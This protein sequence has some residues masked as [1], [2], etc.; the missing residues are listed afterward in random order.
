MI[1]L[2]NSLIKLS[3]H[4][5]SHD[6]DIEREVL[7]P[8][9]MMENPF[10]ANSPFGNFQAGDQQLPNIDIFQLLNSMQQSQGGGGGF[11]FDDNPNQQIP[12]LAGLFASPL[13]NQQSS[14]QQQSQ[15]TIPD[16][17]LVKFLKTKL[18]IVFISMLIY[19]L[20]ATNQQ[21]YSNN[22]VFLY[23]LVWEVAEILLLKSYESKNPFIGFVF[24]MGGVSQH[25]INSFLK[26]IQTMNKILKDVA[27]FVFIFVITHIGYNY[28]TFG[29]GLTEI[30]NENQPQEEIFY[31][32]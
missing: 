2:I 6:P 22:N 15:Q 8:P 27:I 23:L 21:Q 7:E 11:D 32:I 9:V 10:G 25:K 16:S 4:T 19:F 29:K 17:K 13:F 28:F 1:F 14:Q 3:D 20:Y 18:H 24:V 26:I 30:L 5:E 12:N 31:R